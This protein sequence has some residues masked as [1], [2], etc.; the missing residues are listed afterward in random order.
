MRFLLRA[1]PALTL[2]GM[3]IFALTSAAPQQRPVA[4]K[5][6]AAPPNEKPALPERVIGVWQPP[7]G[8][9]QIPIWPGLP[10]NSIGVDLPPERSETGVNRNR[11][12]GLP[13]TGVYDVD[14][15]TMTIFPA[16]GTPNGAAIIVF[17]GGGF[18]QLA[19]DL[20]GTEACG[21]LTVRGFACVLVKYRVPN[22]NHHYD[23]SCDC[24]VTP[25]HLTALQDAQRT[26]RLVR[27][28]AK[29][30]GV[31]P[32]KI[33]VMGFSAGGYLVAQTSNILDPV[34]EAVDAVDALSSRPDFAIALYPGHLCRSGGRL[35]PG[36]RVTRRTPPTFIVQS[37]ND[38]TDEVC[39]TTV[40]ARALDEAG[41]PSEVHLFSKGGHAFGFRP[42]GTPVDVWPTLLDAWL[43]DLIAS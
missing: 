37:W 17:P 21:W 18:K 20:E 12:A 13:V 2:A 3:C 14:R 25:K 29:Q 10:P 22:S 5:K 6:P 26:I 32:D 30:F 40:Y 35:D 19:I 43:D 9:L 27:Q 36:I 1:F 33:G 8:L 11:F 7:G 39:N 34:Y 23:A 38:P 16:K 4:E 41:V 31:A 42:T 15:P 28:R 24:G